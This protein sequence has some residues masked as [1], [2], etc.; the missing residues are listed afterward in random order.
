MATL[1]SI[2]NGNLSSSTTWG[3]VNATSYLDSR[4][5]STTLTTSAVASSTFIPGAI[6]ISGVSI[7]VL[8]RIGVPL[9]STI[10]LQLFNSTTTTV[11]TSVTLNVSDLPNTTNQGIL[12]VGWTYFKFSSNQTLVAGNSYSIRLLTSSA[13][14]VSV[15]RDATA[16]NWSRALVTTTT[17][18]PAATDVLIIGGSYTSAG[19]SVTSTVTMDSTTLATQY[20]Q[21]YV[22]SGGFFNYGITSATNYAL[23]LA[24]D[25]WIGRGGTFTIGTAANPIPAN[26][27]AVLEIN[28]ASALQFQIYNFGTLETKHA[29]T[30]LH[31]ALLNADVTAGATTM[32]TLETTGWKQ[33]DNVIIPSTSRTTTQFERVTLSAD[34]SGT[35]L[36]HGAL[37][38]PHDGNAAIYMQAD[39]GNLTRSIKI[40]STS[41]TFKTRFQQGINGITTFFD[42]EFFEMGTFVHNSGSNLQGGTFNIQQCTFWQTALPGTTTIISSVNTSTYNVSNN[43][44]YN[45]AELAG[46]ITNNN[47]VMGF[48]GF[49]AHF[50][51]SIGSNNVLASSSGAGSSS[52][53]VNGT[54]GN[55]YYSNGGNG[56]LYL[57]AGSANASTVSNYVFFS[58][59]I[60]IRFISG[61]TTVGSDRT[62]FEKFE[63]C[64]F[65]NNSVNIDQLGATFRKLQ[66]NGCFFWGGKV[67]SITSVGYTTLNNDFTYFVDCTFGRRPNGVESNFTTSCL[68]GGQVGTS[69]TNCLFFGPEY[70]YSGAT[71]FTSVNGFN[72]MTSLKHNGITGDYRQSQNNGLVRNDNAITYNGLPTIRITPFI[73]TNKTFS[74]PFRI[75]VQSGA[76]CTVSIAV[77]KSVV[78]DVS[79]AAYNGNQPRLMYAFNPLAGNLTETV[80]VSATNAAN[81][82]WQI[83]TYTTPAVSHDCVL[84]FYVDCDGNAGWI[85]IDDFKTTTSNDTR[86][87]NYWSTVGVYSEPDWRRPGGTVTFIS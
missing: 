54:T 85:N 16:N 86:G 76:T 32:T 60:A 57:T 50:N 15:Y 24:G 25:L 55:R 6:T 2:T 66:F 5:A 43:V 61:S 34:A 52:T 59:S 18:A 30:V 70:S 73:T 8:G 33:N 4:A 12:Y 65:H 3:V 40:R 58:N 84:D 64:Y 49:L 22:G 23:K 42:V 81:G 35:T 47:L 46:T 68:R 39:L 19:V 80:A 13:G 69:L 14:L 41:G 44:F 7:Q 74:N 9:A 48:T 29:T 77:R 72:G 37:A 78:G 45:Y 62:V 38:F 26:S 53:P 71:S 21:C 83:L 11:I 28:C 36:T 27:T 31:R 63:N 1:H 75:A 79:G 87:M 51:G 82:A 20:G 67:G 17:A 10:T 56:A